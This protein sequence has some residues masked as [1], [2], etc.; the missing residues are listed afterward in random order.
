MTGG[1]RLLKKMTAVLL[2][3]LALFAGSAFAV[4]LMSCRAQGIVQAGCCCPTPSLQIPV[5]EHPRLEQGCCE[6]LQ[7]TYASDAPAPSA[8]G[9]FA[10]LSR[11]LFSD[12]PY[13]TFALEEESSAVVPRA[14]RLPDTTGPPLRILHCSYL[15]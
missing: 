10:P 13:E 3:P 9:S 6:G 2:L 8:P 14:T 12:V 4:D 5:D 1:V 7:L 11:P 15:T